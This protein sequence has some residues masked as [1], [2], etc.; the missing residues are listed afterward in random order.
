MQ[1]FARY[2][3]WQGFLNT[4]EF[5]ESDIPSEITLKVKSETIQVTARSS[6]ASSQGPAVWWPSALRSLGTQ[7]CTPWSG[8]GANRFSVRCRWVYTCTVTRDIW[9]CPRV[10]TPWLMAKV[11]QTSNAPTRP[12]WWT[13]AT[14]TT[15]FS[16]SDPISLLFCE[17]YNV[18]NLNVS[19]KISGL[20]GYPGLRE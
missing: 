12:L 10:L 11:G 13:L 1:I 2:S 7:P 18:A 6:P 8:C 19:D 5:I 17:W 9:L 4:L 20:S 14:M 15:V 3:L 16:R